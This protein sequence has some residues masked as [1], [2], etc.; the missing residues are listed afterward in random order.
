[1]TQTADL[2][3]EL[4]EIIELFSES[5]PRERTTLLLDFSEQLPDLPPHLAEKRDELEQVHE[6]MSPVFLHT[7]AENG[8]IYYDIDVPKESPT[9]RGFA[10]ILYQ[11]LNGATPEAIAATPLDLYSHLGLDQVLS[12]QRLN[13][14]TALLSYM[15]R[16]AARL[17]G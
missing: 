2:S 3:P 10:S 11:G 4:R 6:C 14:L 13:G 15:K 7:Y 5:D 9:V 1:M 12:H 16:N 8:R 17:A